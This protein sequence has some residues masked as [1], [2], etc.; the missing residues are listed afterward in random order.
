MLVFVVQDMKQGFCVV[1]LWGVLVLLQE[2][3]VI[4]GVVEI[5]DIILY[6]FLWYGCL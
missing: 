4:A 1:F 6:S 5:T 3:Y 2:G